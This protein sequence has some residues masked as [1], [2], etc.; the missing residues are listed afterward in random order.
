MRLPSEAIWLSDARC[1]DLLLKNGYFL[2]SNILIIRL[3]DVFD[4]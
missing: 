3:V 1:R 4:I 2:G